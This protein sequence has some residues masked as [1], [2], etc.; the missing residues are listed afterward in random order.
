M[1]SMTEIDR[2]S[3]LGF[4]TQK[5]AIRRARRTQRANAVPWLQSLARI[6]MHIVGFSCLTLAG[7]SWNI[8]AGLIVAGISCFAFSWLVTS[9]SKPENPSLR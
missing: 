8:T 7:F 2:L 5:L 3:L 4:V 6:V 9:P 1:V